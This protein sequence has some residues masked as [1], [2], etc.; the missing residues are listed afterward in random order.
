MCI[1]WSWDWKN[2]KHG[3]GAIEKSQHEE[4]EFISNISLLKKKDGKFRPVINLNNLN[5]FVEY[6]N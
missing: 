5:K 4:N 1:D 2:A 3:M 6:H